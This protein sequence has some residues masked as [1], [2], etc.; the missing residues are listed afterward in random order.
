MT[1]QDLKAKRIMQRIPARLL[2]PRA[3]LTCSRLSDI[4]RGYISPSADEL[5]RI[6]K[7]LEELTMARKELQEVA[8]RV[9][10]P[11]ESV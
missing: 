10:W 6:A 7:A 8:E 5:V 1:A 11:M 4:E 3:R 9:G 2:A